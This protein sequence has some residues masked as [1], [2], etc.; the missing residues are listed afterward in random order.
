MSSLI[1]LLILIAIITILYIT[2]WKELVFLH[3]TRPLI[4]KFIEMVRL[5]YD[6]YV[7]YEYDE[8]N[9]IHIIWHN[10]LELQIDKE[11]KIFT[12]NL[13][14]KMFLNND[15]YNIIFR[16]DYFKSENLEKERSTN[17]IKSLKEEEK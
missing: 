6:V 11:F 13:M 9:S 14:K 5:Q 16:Y 3:H 17:Y 1:I 4:L 10:N 15:V 12:N 8:E 2:S 7:G